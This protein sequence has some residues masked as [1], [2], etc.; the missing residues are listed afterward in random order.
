MTTR[1][2]NYSTECPLA[3]TPRAT[4]RGFVCQ[5][6]QFSTRPEQYIE[7]SSTRQNGTSTVRK[8]SSTRRQY[9][10]VR[11]RLWD[12]PVKKT[13]TEILRR[14]NTGGEG[15]TKKNS[16]AGIQDREDKVSSLCGVTDNCSP[17]R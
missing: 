17:A 15:L 6:G 10:E 5:D 12:S 7:D 2:I 11:I 13:D 16:G 3:S 1:K 4:L 9:S 14:D 8:D